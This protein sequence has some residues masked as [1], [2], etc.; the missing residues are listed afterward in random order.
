MAEETKQ[1]SV[2]ERIVEISN[3]LSIGREGKN[4]FQGFKYFKPDDILRQINPLLQKNR[5]FTKF[6]MTFNK[7]KEMYESK[8]TISDIDI[9]ED[10]QR[11]PVEVYQFDI[12]MTHVKGA[13]E[14]QNAGATMTYCKRYMIMNIFNIAD[15][16]VDPD[17]EKNKPADNK[18]ETSAADKS[19]NKKTL[20]QTLLM[21]DAIQNLPT[22]EEWARQLETTEAWNEVQKK[23]IRARLEDRRIM[24]KK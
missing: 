3:E 15:N 6:E 19:K 9:R 21:V 7:E 4:D 1:K 17:N 13:G 23:V 11:G 12:P 8:M 10:L 22:L 18:K 5:L 24:L 2:K 16:E 20:E 14:A